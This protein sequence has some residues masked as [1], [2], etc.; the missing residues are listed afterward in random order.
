MRAVVVHG[1]GD[2]RVEE[3]TP[4]APGPDEIQIQIA[5]AGVCGSDLH[6]YRS[7]RVGAFEVRE[8]LVVG[9]EVVGRVLRDGREATDPGAALATGT[10]VTLHPATP[11]QRLPG[12]EH[13]PSVWPN[14]RYLG[15]AATL[16][17]TQGAMSDLFTARVDQVRV[18]PASLPLERAVLAEPL[19]VALHALNRAGGVRGRSVLVS[20][21]GPIG[22]LVAGAAV[23][24]GATDVA[25]CDV[26]A[27]PLERGAPLG[28]S[29]TFR[30]GVDT[31]PAEEFDVVLECAGVPAALDQAIRSVARG[32]VVV[33]VGILPGEARPYDL[34]AVVSREIDVRGSF[35][36]DGE[37][38]EAIAMLDATPALGSVVT[39]LFAAGDAVSAFDRAADARASSK[40]VIRFDSA[41][42]G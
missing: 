24:S 5:Y 23:A 13:R 30:S 8:P 12:L 36:F 4:R 28:V 2:L 9:H 25:L 38:D 18:L 26:L 17:H 20:G 22:L 14:T 3:R 19:G 7:G 6:Y 10:P 37:L 32:G 39:D 42:A 29:R 16:P 1:A 27:E 21:A 33:Q 34:S 35:R 41:A 31:I 40:V 15:S 11:G